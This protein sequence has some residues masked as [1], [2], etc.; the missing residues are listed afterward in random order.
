MDWSRAAGWKRVVRLAW[1]ALLT[2]RAILDLFGLLRR[3]SP[4]ASNDRMGL[5]QRLKLPSETDE[6]WLDN[7]DLRPSAS[8]PLATTACLL[9]TSF[10][11]PVRASHLDLYLLLGLL[12]LCRLDCVQLVSRSSSE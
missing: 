7:E 2:T 10:S 3:T 12:V 11:S 4:H 9:T 1:R 5:L 8:C 6:P